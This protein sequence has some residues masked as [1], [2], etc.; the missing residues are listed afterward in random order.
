[1]IELRPGE[2]ILQ[3]FLELVSEYEMQD[4]VILQSSE[5]DVLQRIEEIYPDMPKLFLSFNKDQLA[6][7][8][9]A[10]HVD[11][12]AVSGG[13][14]TQAYCDQVH[15]AGKQYCVYVVNAT[16]SI[17][18]AIE[19]GVDYYFTDFTGKAFTLEALYR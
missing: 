6:L 13:L 4:N 2:E 12:I 9:Q 7:A 5:L 19:M 1:M 18:K 10:D 15:A 16:S 17:L 14:F 3:R 11:I 8:L